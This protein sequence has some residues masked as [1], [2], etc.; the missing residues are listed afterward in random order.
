MMV[1]LGLERP[2]PPTKVTKAPTKE[3]AKVI[4]KTAGAKRP[5]RQ[6]TVET[7]EQAPAKRPAPVP[8]Q[9]VATATVARSDGETTALRFK[10]T[11]AS[12]SAA[13]SGIY[14][15]NQTTVD[16]ISYSSTE[17]GVEYAQVRMGKKKGWLAKEYLTN[18][19]PPHAV[20][21]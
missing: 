17:T 5:R 21:A 9:V 12:T 11:D 19:S 2:E 3:R 7:V 15:D 10:A 4:N 16:I 14:L 6:P 20:N 1:Q 18:I 13:F 8:A